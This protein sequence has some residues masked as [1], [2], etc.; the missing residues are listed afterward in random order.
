MQ[1]GVAQ[2]RPEVG[3]GRAK[4]TDRV[5][6]AVA[7][8]NEGEIEKRLGRGDRTEQI[9]PHAVNERED[10]DQNE[11]DTRHVEGRRVRTADVDI[12]TGLAVVFWSHCCRS[13]S[14][15][16]VAGLVPRIGHVLPAA[17]GR[18]QMVPPCLMPVPAPASQ[19]KKTAL[20]GAG[21]FE[22]RLP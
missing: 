16:V 11:D 14:S 20:R 6:V 7:A 18:P 3:A 15:G 10:R 8:R 17:Q 1:E 9:D 5:D 13:P 2:R 4:A 21:R 19:N 22:M 12:G